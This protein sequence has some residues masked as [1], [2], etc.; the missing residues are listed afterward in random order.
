MTVE[1]R[2]LWQQAVIMT[3]RAGAATAVA[4]VLITTADSLSN[5]KAVLGIALLVVAALDLG[6]KVHA[7]RHAKEAE[8]AT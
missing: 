7:L 8:D 3:C 6:W 1:S 2:H 5:W 4:L